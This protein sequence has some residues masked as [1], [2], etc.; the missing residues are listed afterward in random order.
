M[1]SHEGVTQENVRAQKDNVEGDSLVGGR[2]REGGRGRRVGKGSAALLHLFCPMCF[3]TSTMSDCINTVVD[4][5]PS[6]HMHVP[7]NH[8]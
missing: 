8:L 7:K 3:I 1:S 6:L 2:K 5:N 4:S